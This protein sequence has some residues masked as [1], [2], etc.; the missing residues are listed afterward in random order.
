[1]QLM[2]N[3][4]NRREFV[5]LI[6]RNLEK[7]KLIRYK[8]FKIIINRINSNF[9]S[10]RDTESSTRI[11]DVGSGPGIN[12]GFLL[13]E[14]YDVYG[15][16]LDFD[17]LSLYSRKVDRGAKVVEGLSQSLPFKSNIF[18]G[19]FMFSLIEHVPEWKET[20]SECARILKKG[21]ILYITTTNKMHPFQGEVEKIPLYPWIPQKL[22]DILLKIIMKK[23]KALVGYTDYPAVNWFT[24]YSLRSFL[25]RIGFDVYDAIDLSCKSEFKGI[26]GIIRLL[27]DLRIVRFIYYFYTVTVRIVAQK[28]VDYEI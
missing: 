12:M 19:C 8:N 18:D 5:K 21:G 27:L 7:S 24:Y 6:E 26:K 10:L 14:G 11:L 25:T 15:I 17:L 1:M 22:K 2:N 20:L 16:D 23:Y 28:N 9:P 3:D 13:N 4:C